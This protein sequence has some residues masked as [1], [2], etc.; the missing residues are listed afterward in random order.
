MIRRIVIGLALV[1]IAFGLFARLDSLGTKSLWTDETFS[2]LRASGHH[3][4]AI[5]ALFDGRV[6]RAGALAELQTVG[7][8]PGLGAAIASLHEEPQRGPLYYVVLRFWALAFGSG[9][10][11]DRLL[12]SLL[13]IVGIGLAYLLG[14]ELTRDRT[15][16]LVLAALFAISPM[17][18]RYAQQI[19][20]YVLL[21]DLALLS[22]YLT[23]RVVERPS[24]AWLA[25]VGASVLAGVYT[26]PTFVFLACA[27]V[28]VAGIAAR[29]ARAPQI[30][31]GA[32]VSAFV[33]A[34]LYAP[35]ALVATRNAS[36]AAAGVSW[37]GSSYSLKSSAM[38]WVFNTGAVFF[39]SEYAHL[40]WS[41]VLVPLLALVAFAAYR[42]IVRRDA[43]P[44]RAIALALALATLVPLVVLDLLHRSHFAL[45]ARYEMT[46]WVGVDVLVALAIVDALGANRPG[47]GGLAVTAFAF[48]IAAGTLSAAVDRRYSDWWDN[49]DHV[50]ERAIGEAIA[51]RG[52]AGLVV[53]G[54]VYPT[55]ALAR[56]L[57]PQTPLLLT[58][59]VTRAL[60]HVDGPLY[61]VTPSADEIAAV[62]TATGRT[63]QNV[64]PDIG[65]ALHDLTQ[66]GA[67]DPVSAG[68]A[69]WT[70]R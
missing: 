53:S 66:T 16:G 52:P 64:S 68:N 3:E 54:S 33:A 43:L 34:L 13:G 46:T 58:G 15:G 60:P 1:A 24:A 22:A 25:A 67:A 50:S 35:W 40:G 49:N 56:Y 21:A 45:V 70:V 27:E 11:R 55:F 44:P 57:A 39:D 42:A 12:S 37:A 4:K 14:R 63:P 48:A 51:A 29:R 59:D 20:E 36:E 10:A 9:I 26:N 18:I 31:I 69:L 8:S 5:Y 19:R 6:H 30:A 38:K 65:L 41:G 32:F 17:E 7:P 61:L 23:V 2:M 62:A 28:I 47:V